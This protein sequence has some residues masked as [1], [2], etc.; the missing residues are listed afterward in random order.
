LK[1]DSGS[2]GPPAQESSFRS[3]LTTDSK[4]LAGLLRAGSGSSITR[5]PAGKLGLQLKQLGI[6]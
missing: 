3:W 5:W 6:L 2:P 4:A 1:S